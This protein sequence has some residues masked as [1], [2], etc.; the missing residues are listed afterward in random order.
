MIQKSMT[1]AERPK[2]TQKSIERCNQFIKIICA[3]SLT[4]Y[5]QKLKKLC[6]LNTA[7]AVYI[8]YK[9]LDIFR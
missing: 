4:D 7:E 6:F 9:G 5:K 8:E 2:K 3:N 1:W